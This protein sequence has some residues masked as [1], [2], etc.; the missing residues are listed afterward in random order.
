[1]DKV[2]PGIFHIYLVKDA[3]VYCCELLI[4]YAILRS[5]FPYRCDDEIRVAYFYRYEGVVAGMRLL[6]FNEKNA[7]IGSVREIVFGYVDSIGECGFLVRKQR[8]MTC[9][10]LDPFCI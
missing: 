8:Q 1:M 2:F 4:C 3:V 7:A 6:R 10:Q 9:R 5:S